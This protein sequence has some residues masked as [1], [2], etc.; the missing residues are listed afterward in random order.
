MVDIA[1]PA[2]RPRRLRAAAF[3][4]ELSRE[5]RLVAGQLIQPLFV[6][7]GALC[8]PIASMPGQSRLDL[9]QL[10]AEAR[11]LA[12]LGV[13]AVAMFPFSISTSSSSR[14]LGLDKYS[15]YTASLS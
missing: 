1:Y 8:G 15:P 7:E 14:L 3:S 5:T 13:S 10:A 2:T 12:A 9:D 11:A 4:R 6:A